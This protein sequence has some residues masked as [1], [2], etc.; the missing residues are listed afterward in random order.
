MW[1]LFRLKSGLHQQRSQSSHQFGCEAHRWT[2]SA[3]RWHQRQHIGNEEIEEHFELR[4]SDSDFSVVTTKAMGLTIQVG[5]NSFRLSEFFKEHPPRIKFVDQSSLEGNILVKVSSVPP[6]FNSENIAVL[7]WTGTNI[8]NESQ[9]R[10][11]DPQ[12]FLA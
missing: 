3:G 6:T 4:I 12:S 11:R 1:K 8:Q 10:D 9:T 2:Y 7:D 5:K